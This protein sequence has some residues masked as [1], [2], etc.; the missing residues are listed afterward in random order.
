[1]YGSVCKCSGPTTLEDAV[2][3]IARFGHLCVDSPWLRQLLVCWVQVGGAVDSGIALHSC[4]FQGG[5]QI[6][7]MIWHTKTAV[8]LWSTHIC[9][10]VFFLLWS[11]LHNMHLLLSPFWSVLSCGVKYMHAVVQPSPPSVPRTV[12]SSQTRPVATKP[13]L[14]PSPSSWLPPSTFCFYAFGSSLCPM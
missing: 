8:F 14:F 9:V 3:L 6:V 4:I 10:Y 11:N 5:E 2:M 13:P 12:F 1:M 7:V